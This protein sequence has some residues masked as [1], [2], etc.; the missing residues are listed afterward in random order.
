MNTWIV[1]ALTQTKEKMESQLRL[2]LI[3]LNQYI[4]ERL[5]SLT[6]RSK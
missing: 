6:K 5:I 4:S 1:P 3:I 2:Q